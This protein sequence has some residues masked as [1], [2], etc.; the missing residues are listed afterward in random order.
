MLIIAITND[1]VLHALGMT[2]M[3]HTDLFIGFY[4][5]KPHETNT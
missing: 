4:E 5:F 1:F 3:M 2:S